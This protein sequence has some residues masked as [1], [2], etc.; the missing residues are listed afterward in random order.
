MRKKKRSQLSKLRSAIRRLRIEL[1]T[2]KQVHEAGQAFERLTVLQRD[3]AWREN[4][5]LSGLLRHQKREY[6]VL[7]ARL[8][9]P[10]A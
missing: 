2:E 8:E 1:K 5:A 3:D 4:E 7:L 10:R 9:Y 6:A